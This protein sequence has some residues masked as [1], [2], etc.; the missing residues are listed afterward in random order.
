MRPLSRSVVVCFAAA[1]GAAAAQA[2]DASV[3]VGTVRSF[4]TVAILW[5]VEL[6]TS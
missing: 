2:Q 4:S 5:A 1:I 6:A 3:K